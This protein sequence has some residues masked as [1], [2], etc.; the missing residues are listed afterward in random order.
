MTTPVG[1]VTYFLTNFGDIHWNELSE[2]DKIR[3]LLLRELELLNVKFGS[4]HDAKFNSKEAV[5]R[6]VKAINNGKSN[7]HDIIFK[8]MDKDRDKDKDKD[9][10]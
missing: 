3:Q 2:G 4:W 5:E 7:I 10:H 8:R 6:T 1:L 9:S